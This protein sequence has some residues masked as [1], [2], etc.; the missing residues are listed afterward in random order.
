MS[1][2]NK[3]PRALCL[4]DNCGCEFVDVYAWIA[5]PSAFWSSFFHLILAYI[6]YRSIAVKDQKMKLWF[7]SLFLL[8]L[9]SL[10]GHGSFLEI[11]IASDFAGII[12]V[13]SY[14]SLYF[15]ISKFRFSTLKLFLFLCLYFIGLTF[16][17]Y[18]LEKWTKVSLCLIV[19]GLAVFEMIKHNGLMIFKQKD[20]QISLVLFLISFGFFLIDE[21]KVFC[22]PSS[23]L[24]GHSLWHLGTAFGLNYYGR[25]RLQRL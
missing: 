23:W 25:F 12:L 4:P 16:S 5:Q 11:A 8:A 18:S 9:G 20:L 15:W 22:D 6:F 3:F 17:F 2:W 7:L 14:F 21:L 19:V 24:S 10:I 13:T 1:P